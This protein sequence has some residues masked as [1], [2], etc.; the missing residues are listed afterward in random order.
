MFIIGDWLLTAAAMLPGN[1]VGELAF[2]CGSY[3]I[4]NIIH[5]YL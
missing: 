4:K 3:F 2:D 1:L 5:Y